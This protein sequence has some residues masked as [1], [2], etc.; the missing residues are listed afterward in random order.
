MTYVRYGKA[1][2]PV[3]IGNLGAPSSIREQSGADGGGGRRKK[4]QDVTHGPHSAQRPKRINQC[5]PHFTHTFSTTG[6]HMLTLSA[7]VAVAAAERP[8]AVPVES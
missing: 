1:T 6:L 5:T 8:A 4:R 2:F 3:T 7:V